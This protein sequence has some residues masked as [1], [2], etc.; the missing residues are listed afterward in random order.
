[1]LIITISKSIN[2][3]I[4][5]N[6][7]LLFRLDNKYKYLIFDYN[8]HYIIISYYYYYYILR[9]SAKRYEK[10]L[11]IRLEKPLMNKNPRRPSFAPFLC[12]PL[13]INDR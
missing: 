1:M 13:L 12:S 5:Y 11:A 9:L 3:Y 6:I 2:T 10:L 4:L 8:T 7:R